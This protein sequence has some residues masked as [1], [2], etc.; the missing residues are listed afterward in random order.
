MCVVAWACERELAAKEWTTRD[1]KSSVEADLV[2][3]DGELV[4]LKRSSDGK[5]FK[6]PFSRLS[7]GDVQYV[8][9][10]MKAAFGDNPPKPVP[11]PPV[12][13]GAPKPAA[14]VTASDEG[15]PLASADKTGWQVKPDPASAPWSL[16]ANHQLRIS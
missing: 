16:P 13:S 14:N 10:A 12:G 1:G 9:E 7:L 2:D 11:T 4:I 6:V 3:V 5:L 15:L 8:R